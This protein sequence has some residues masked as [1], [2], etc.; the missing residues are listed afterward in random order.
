MPRNIIPKGLTESTSSP[1]NFAVGIE[2]ANTIARASDKAATLADAR[3]T[4]IRLLE[5]LRT[6]NEPAAAPRTGR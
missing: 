1:K 5:S 2:A 6:A 4:V 3:E